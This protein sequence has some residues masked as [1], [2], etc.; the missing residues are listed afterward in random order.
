MR[1]FSAATSQ[2]CPLCRS[3]AIP[4]LAAPLQQPQEA[5][6]PGL[7]AL[8]SQVEGAP[9]KLPSPLCR[10]GLG[11]GKGEALFCVRFCFLLNLNQHKIDRRDGWC[12]TKAGC[13]PRAA[14]P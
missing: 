10:I 14:I 9:P 2:P 6:P 11:P 7:L 3:L 13:P 4:A 1:A 5:S 8:Q 12:V